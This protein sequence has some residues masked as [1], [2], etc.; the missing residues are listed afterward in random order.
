MK[1]VLTMN[2]QESLDLFFHNENKRI[3]A[4]EITDQAVLICK[5]MNT[6]TVDELRKVVT[7]PENTDARIFGAVLARKIFEP[8]GF[9][10]TKVKSSHGRPIRVFRLR[11]GV[12]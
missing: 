8:V 7:L 12:L 9:T 2:K 6:V 3:L 11:E 5:K 4:E 1:K 10:T